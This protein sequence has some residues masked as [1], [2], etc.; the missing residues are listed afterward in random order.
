V[1]VWGRRLLRLKRLA[2]DE[3][4]DELAEGVL[5]VFRGD[6]DFVGEFFIS[7]TVRATETVLDQGFREATGE[8]LPMFGG[9][10]FTQFKEV[11][12]CRA[13][14]EL[15][16]A[17]DGGGGSTGHHIA[18]SV[19]GVSMF[20]AALF[21]RGSE[22]LQAKANR[23]DLAMTAGALGF[24]HVSRKFLPLGEGLSVQT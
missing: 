3:G 6:Q 4:V 10:Q 8:I 18:F 14:V 23:I 15:A 1:M 5:L 20:P 11:G 21:A 16:G 13:V 7:E 17:V 22:I 12:E 24:F 2:L 9:K 19:L